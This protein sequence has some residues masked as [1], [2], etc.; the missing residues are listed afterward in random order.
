M[1]E[2]AIL[3][4]MLIVANGLCE[5]AAQKKLFFG[6]GL[7]PAQ[8]KK[9]LAALVHYLVGYRESALGN[10]M[11]CLSFHVEGTRWNTN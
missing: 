1:F 3:L 11:L 2:P 8:L 4:P 10:D 9:R 6:F 5:D 7:V